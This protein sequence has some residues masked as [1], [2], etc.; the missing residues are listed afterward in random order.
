MVLSRRRLGF[1]L[2]WSLVALVVAGVLA[3]FS[4]AEVRYLAQAAW[5]EA[6]ILRSARPISDVVRD[7]TTPSRTRAQLELVLDARD[8][9]A[10]LGFRAGDTYTT[11]SDVGRDTLLLVLSAAPRNCLCPYTWRYP[12]V[13]RIP[14]KGFFDPA[15]A[16]AAAARLKTQGY[17]VNLRPSGA[18]ST[19]GWFQDPLLSTALTRDSVELA[20]TVFH[21]IAHNTLW[22]P[23][24]AA[25]NE[26]FAQFAGYHAAA[27]FFRSRGDSAASQRALDRWH[28]EM[29][30]GRYYDQLVSR[31]ESLYALKLDSAAVDSGRAAAA[32]WALQQ[33]EGPVGSDLRTYR[34]GRLRSQPINNAQLIGVRLYRTRLDL[35][36]RWYQEHGSDTRR[37][38]A[39]LKMALGDVTGDSAFVRLAR[40]VAA[41]P[42]ANAPGS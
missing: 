42:N 23:S 37:T 26:S 29:V 17:D 16:R 3:Y 12:I 36:N 11:Y 18:F 41:S 28:D 5:E 6:R 9:A 25:F 15:M 35:F 14:Y 7:S 2:L 4:S 27:E 21:E 22:V 30:L 39:D 13:G 8:Y 24:A 1:A 32:Q 20:A 10:K 34:I 19:L 38:V 31:L 33:L 40:A